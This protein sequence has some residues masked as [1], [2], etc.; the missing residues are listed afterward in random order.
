[1]DVVRQRLERRDVD[2]LRR[3]RERRLE[4][5]SHQVV[6]SGQKGRERLARSRRRGNEGV[7][8]GLDR[9]PSFGLRGG[10]GGETV[11]E[12]VRNRRVEQRFDDG[13]R[14]RRGRAPPRAG[15]RG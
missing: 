9:R 14:S 11:G 10:R 4:T 8:A 15:P 13:R 7:A 6:D 1:M 12:P 2:D 5:L 3:I